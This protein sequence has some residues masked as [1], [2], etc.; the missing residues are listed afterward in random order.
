MSHHQLPELPRSAT[1]TAPRA[2]RRIIGGGLVALLLLLLPGQPAAAQ[3]VLTDVEHWETVSYGDAITFNVRA[4]APTE[5]AAARLIV[6]ARHLS[7]PHVAD[8]PVAPGT[9]VELAQTV[10]VDALAL[11]PFASL[12]V[13]WEFVDTA[14]VLYTT[15]PITVLYLDNSLPWAWARQTEGEITVYT[16]GTD[17]LVASIALEIAAD[18]LG[19]A[20]HALGVDGPDEVHLFVYPELPLMAQSLQSHGENVQDWVAAY[21]IPAYH[22]AFVA[23]SPQEDLRIN[24]ERDI[25]HEMTHLV[26]ASAAGGQARQFPGW[27][28]EGLA[29]MSAPA[30]DPTLQNV[31]LEAAAGDNLLPLEAL[32]APRFGGLSPQDM[33]L[34]YAESQSIMRYISSRFGM[35]Q[36][37]ALLGE[38]AAGAGCEE[39]VR[40]AL[41]V[42]LAQLE[43]QWHN[44][45]LNQAARTP[46]GEGSLAAWLVMWLVSVGL[47]LLFIAP[48]PN[49]PTRRRA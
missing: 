27:F 22:A 26:I 43:T 36:V 1:N 44:D 13:T 34:A 24:L 3:G 31:L 29:L 19:S 10:P 28:N 21:A 5:I 16:D 9:A 33:A 11:P 39:G 35:W 38:Y 30:P 15:R 18:A 4:A 20:R 46:Q 41:G 14:G 49:R 40:R 32:C 8:V 42:S 45:L 6:S 47:A 12:E 25:P 48:Q 17:P 23:A 2:L 7:E 37:Q